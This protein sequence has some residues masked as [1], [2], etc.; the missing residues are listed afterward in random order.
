MIVDDVLMIVWFIL[1]VAEIILKTQMKLSLK[2]IAANAIKHHKLTY[3][4]QVP[5]ALESFIELH[6]PGIKKA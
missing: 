2:C 1:G 5:Q 3:E 6:G 4:G